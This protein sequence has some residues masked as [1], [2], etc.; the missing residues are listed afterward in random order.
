MLTFVLDS[1][2]TVDLPTKFNE[3]TFIEIDRD[4]SVIKLI[5]SYGTFLGYDNLGNIK[6]GRPLYLGSNIDTNFNAPRLDIA[7]LSIEGDHTP[8]VSASVPLLLDSDLLTQ[9]P[10]TSSS[11]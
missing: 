5:A 4:L 7:F 3:S 10:G 1:S 9:P 8:P 6:T 11:E 2:F